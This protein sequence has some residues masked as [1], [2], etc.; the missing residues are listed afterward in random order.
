MIELSA[1]SSSERAS[2]GWMR[3]VWDSVWLGTGS[4]TTQAGSYEGQERTGGDGMKPN[5]T[6]ELAWIKGELVVMGRN[7]T[8]KMLIQEPL[9]SPG[10]NLFGINPKASVPSS[11]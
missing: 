2:H 9:P 1:I 4:F 7:Q 5:P 8:M 11:R 10:R 3:N 6:L